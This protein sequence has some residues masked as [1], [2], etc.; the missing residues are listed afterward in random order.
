MH[1]RVLDESIC[2]DE[3]VVRGVV[4]HIQDTGLSC[5]FC[6]RTGGKAHI[7]T[8]FYSRIKHKTYFNPPGR[9]A[10]GKKHA[11]EQLRAASRPPHLFELHSKKT[12]EEPQIGE[13]HLRTMQ[14]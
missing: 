6:S 12:A 14:A 9:Q 5:N 10:R 2:A 13:I 7:N 8:T 1:D 11:K 3:L 4:N